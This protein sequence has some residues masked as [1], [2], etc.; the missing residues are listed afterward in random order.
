M[1]KAVKVYHL[2]TFANHS[3]AGRQESVNIKSK[4]NLCIRSLYMDF[5]HFGFHILHWRSILKI[6]EIHVKFGRY[7]PAKVRKRK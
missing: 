3:C 6:E 2:Q 5:T 4:S 1:G 7:P